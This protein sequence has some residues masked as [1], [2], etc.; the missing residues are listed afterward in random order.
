MARATFVSDFRLL[1]NSVLRRWDSRALDELMATTAQEIE[2]EMA[3]SR[4]YY[5][6]S[7][8]RPTPERRMEAEEVSAG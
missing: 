3:R 1:V 6:P 5:A 8:V 4:A 7:K 2:K